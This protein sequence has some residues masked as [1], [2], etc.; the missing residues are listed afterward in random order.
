MCVAPQPKL[1]GKNWPSVEIWIEI[2]TLLRGGQLWWHYILYL[3]DE[4][5]LYLIS[6]YLSPQP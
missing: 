2:S 1:L 5:A 6:L 4:E 3:P